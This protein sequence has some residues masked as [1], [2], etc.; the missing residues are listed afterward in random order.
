MQNDIEAFLQFINTAP[1]AELISRLKAEYAKYRFGRVV[2]ITETLINRGE[3]DEDIF[4]IHFQLTKLGITPNEEIEQAALR[5]G[6]KEVVHLQDTLNDVRAN[7]KYLQFMEYMKSNKFTE[8]TMSLG[9]TLLSDGHL[10]AERQ[11]KVA[12]YVHLM[13]SKIV[14]EK[15]FIP[16][17]DDTLPVENAVIWENPSELT[18]T[19]KS[20]QQDVDSIISRIRSSKGIP[21]KDKAE[22]V[23]EME[24]K[25]KLKDDKMK[26]VF[27]KLDTEGLLDVARTP[28]DPEVVKAKIKQIGP[29]GEN[30]EVVIGISQKLY[31]HLKFILGGAGNVVRKVLVDQLWTVTTRMFSVLSVRFLGCVAATAGFAYVLPAIP[32][33]LSAG[34]GTVIAFFKYLLLTLFN[35]IPA[36]ASLLVTELAASLGGMFEFVG[37]T[38]LTGSLG[39]LVPGSSFIANAIAWLTAHPIRTTVAIGVGK[40]LDSFVYAFSSVLFRAPINFLRTL[41]MRMCPYVASYFTARHKKTVC[42]AMNQFLIGALSTYDTPGHSDFIADFRQDTKTI[43]QQIEIDK[44]LRYFTNKKLEDLD[45]MTPEAQVRFVN[46]SYRVWAVKNHADKAENKEAAEEKFAAESKQWEILKKYFSV[47]PRVQED[48]DEPDDIAVPFDPDDPYG[49][50]IDDDDN[51]E[52]EPNN[53]EPPRQPNGCPVGIDPKLCN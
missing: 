52:N 30:A 22:L 48:R 24:N 41:V 39:S 9:K 28:P 35:M 29:N 19:V 31:R 15:I 7:S 36:S 10:D 37:L 14:E 42:S 23:S 5:Y 47:Q 46:R 44:M 2:A 51:G 34:G 50:G 4:E 40:C 53:D 32:A 1:K 11:A 33:L 17:V 45:K 43:E 21:V 16:N 18:D 27:N 12:H 49:L 38:S 25:F 26:V 13:E 20:I 3:A 8:Y 6:R